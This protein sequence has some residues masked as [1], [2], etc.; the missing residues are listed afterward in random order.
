MSFYGSVQYQLGDAFAKI[1]LKNSGKELTDFVAESADLGPTEINAKNRTSAIPI[2]SGNRWIQL[3]KSEDDNIKFYHAPADKNA[4]T[5]TQ[6]L[7]PVTDEELKSGVISSKATELKHGDYLAVPV[8]YIDE[9]GH[10]VTTKST[11]VAYYRLPVDVKDIEIGQLTTTVNEHTK[12]IADHDKRLSSAE[13]NA[14]SALDKIE[15]GLGELSEIADQNNS[16]QAIVGR[17]QDIR[18]AMSNG[19]LTIAKYFQSLKNDIA[20]NTT[21]IT[22]SN[23]SF[24]LLNSN[25]EALTERVKALEE[26]NK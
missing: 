25:V 7:Q 11:G 12:N 17:W 10:V 15:S 2:D 3:V 24:N 16:M 21:N 8:M 13:G 9:A 14:K 1:Y 22:A 23:T 26:K 5:F 19:E 4:T 20:N 18:D 6:V